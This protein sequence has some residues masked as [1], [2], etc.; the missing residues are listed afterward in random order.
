MYVKSEMELSL[1]A[2]RTRK[3]L[4]FFTIKH[5]EEIICIGK[6]KRQTKNIEKPDAIL[7]LGL[8]YPDDG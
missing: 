4:D 5:K 3:K 6:K 7:H 8:D 2:G 1:D